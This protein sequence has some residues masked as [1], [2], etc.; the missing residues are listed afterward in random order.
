[1]DFAQN[2]KA[3]LKQLPLR[4]MSG[5]Q[6]FIAVAAFCVKGSLNAEI[7]TNEVQ[8]LWRKSLLTIS[9]N[10][11]FY[12]RAQAAGWADPLPKHGR[13]H[14][15]EAGI[16]NLDALMPEFTSKDLTKSGSLAIFGKKATHS[17]DKF[18]RTTF[19][20]TRKQVLIAD[21]WV[22][23]TIFDTVLDVIPK[24]CN[25]R[26]LYAQSR[27]RFEEKARR[28]A[29]QYPKYSHKRYKHLHDRFIIVDESAYIVG[30]SIKD[31]ASHSP[32]IVVSLGTKEKNALQ[33]FFHELW[34]M[35]K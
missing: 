1:M 6:K 9:F 24:D 26:L 10:S 34:S 21:S 27:D 19:A 32:A 35:A 12:H 3:F 23:G 13:F 11:I 5:H 17:F 18:L 14:L 7:S 25:F 20:A 4:K 33:Q 28:F 8:K 31:A 29:Q 30:P 22:D 15:T 16:D 2:L